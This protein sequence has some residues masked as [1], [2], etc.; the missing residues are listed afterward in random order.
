MTLAEKLMISM[1]RHE[2]R[3]WAS[4]W[5]QIARLDLKPQERAKLTDVIGQWGETYHVM[6]LREEEYKLEKGTKQ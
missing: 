4:V 1:Q 3:R 6:K 5:Y 2:K